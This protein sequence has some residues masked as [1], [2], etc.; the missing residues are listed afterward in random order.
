MNGGRVYVWEVPVRLT[1]WVTVLAILVLSGTGFYIGDPIFGGSVS[2]MAWMRGVHRITAYVFIAGVM[3][4]TYWAFAGNEWASWRA[5]FPYLTAEGRRQMAR[6]FLYYTFFR[7]Q[8]PGGLGHNPLAGM[9]YSAV[10]AL[11]IAE[12]LTGFALQSLG[13]GGWRRALFGWIFSLISLQGVRLVHHMIMWLLLGFAVHH[14]YSSVLMDLE[15]KNGLLTSIFTGY[16]FGR[17]RA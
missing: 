4:R 8:P 14:V 17:R 3:L 11:M 16:K 7:R 2:L 12:I 6:T 10:V 9:A 13:G 1:H 5:L 15:E